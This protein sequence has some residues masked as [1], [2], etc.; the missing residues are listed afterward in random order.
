MNKKSEL[1]F[2]VLTDN[3]LYAIFL[4]HSM[5]DFVETVW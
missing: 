5:I 1:S 4:K 2:F 3:K